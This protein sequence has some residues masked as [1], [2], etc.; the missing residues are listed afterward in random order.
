MTEKIE[1]F[2][3]NS[4]KITD[5]V[6]NIYIDTFK[7]QKE[8]HDAKFIFVTHEH[9]DHFNPEDIAKVSNKDTILVVPQSMKEKAL[10]VS[11]IVGRIE[12][13]AV[14]GSYTIDGLS[15]ETIPAYNIGKPF[16]QK[17][18]EW[19]GYILI[20]DGKRIYIAGDT[21][22]TEEA[23][24]VKCDIALVPIGG[25]YTMDAKEAAELVNILKPEVAI[26]THFG[27][28]VGTVSDEEKFAVFVK[29]P[30]KVEQKKQY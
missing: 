4:I 22:A 1:V 27:G 7:M 26:P 23:K 9:Y 8:T 18:S 19:V 25:K 14:N 13:V 10:E 15:F 11:D 30:T 28:I 6:G 29:A 17:E 12:T 3:Q 20:V 21:D 24:K 2:T 5:T 16:H